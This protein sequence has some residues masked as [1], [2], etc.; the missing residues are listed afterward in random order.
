M[1][2]LLLGCILLARTTP[3]AA[4]L[5]GCNLVVSHLLPIAIS[6][7]HL[8]A[9]LL[10][11]IILLITILLLPLLPLALLP[12][13]LALLLLRLLLPPTDELLPLLFVLKDPG[14]PW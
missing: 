7:L 9:A 6:S 2:L 12:L 13:P 1:H 8:I 3:A 4:D 5:P 11:L 14:V 10:V